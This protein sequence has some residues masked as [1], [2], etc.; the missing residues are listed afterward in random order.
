VLSSV[1]APFLDLVVPSRCPACDRPRRDAGGGGVCADCWATLPRAAASCP[2]CALPG[3]AGACA[4]CRH[5][6]PPLER[7]VAAGVYAGPL[8]RIVIAFKFRGLDTLAAPAAR[9]MAAALARESLET[10]DAIVPVPSTPR[11]N[12]ERGYDPALLLARA[13][14]HHLGRPV[15][16]LLRRLRDDV[17]QSRLCATERRINVQGAFAAR[18]AHGRHLLLVDDVATTGAT[19]FA[20]ARA[21]RGAGAA[22]VD[23][24]LLARTPEPEDF[25]HPEIT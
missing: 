17:A 22:R 20:A 21:L 5:E 2:R 1:L 8:A 16:R 25:R 19:A 23:L 6:E 3:S 13:L 18:A 7:S 15:R 10:P 9:V 14:A 12:R 11:R 24:V 4:D